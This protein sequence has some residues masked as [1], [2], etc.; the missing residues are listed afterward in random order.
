MGGG[1]KY[2]SVRNRKRLNGKKAGTLAVLLGQLTERRLLY[3]GLGGEDI[4]LKDVPLPCL[5]ISNGM[6]SLSLDC[7][8]HT[9][10]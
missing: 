10:G 2:L 6:L 1:L 9:C 7:R 8:M 4:T 5:P 3:W